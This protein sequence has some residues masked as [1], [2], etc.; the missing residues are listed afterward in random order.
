MVLVYQVVCSSARET[1]LFPPQEHSYVDYRMGKM[2]GLAT[3]VLGVLPQ[4]CQ[5]GEGL[6]G[7]G[8]LPGCAP[9]FFF[10]PVEKKTATSTHPCWEDE[11]LLG[12]PARCQLLP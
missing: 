4:V 1:H 7:S 10:L 11:Y 12:P 9:F 3:S 8:Q 6:R 2:Y 5:A